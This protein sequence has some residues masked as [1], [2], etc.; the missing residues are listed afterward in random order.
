MRGGKY[1]AAVILKIEPVKRLQ[2]TLRPPSDKSLTH[3]AYMLGAI[4]AGESMVREPLLGEDCEATLRCLR[5]MGLCAEPDGTGVRLMPAD[6]WSQPHDV[7][8]CGNSGTT[9]RLMSGLVASRPLD[10]TMVGDASLSRRPMKRIAEPLRL[11][12]AT[13][14]GDTPPLRIKGGNLQSITYESPVA[15]AQIKSA[16]LLAGLR[17]QGRTAVIEPSLSRDHTERMLSALGVPVTLS[18]LGHSV[19]ALDGPAQPVGFEF[20]VPGDVSSGAFFMV[21]AAVIDSSVLDVLELG[22]NPSRTGVLDV[23]TMAGVE[24]HILREWQELGEPVADIAIQS[25]RGLRPFTIE[26]AMVPRLIDEIPV[27]AV[28]ATQCEGTTV[29]RDARELRVKESDRIE[30]VANG[31]RAMGAKVETFDDGLAVT[32][33]TPLRSA[34]ID[35]QLDHRIAMAFAVAGLI[36]DGGVEIA[37]AEAIGTSFPGFESELRRLTSV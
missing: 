25:A 9:M 22:V 16:V 27:L 28:L 18:D 36:S 10:V 4:A 3:R 23:L 21:A 20:L 34:T 37:G 26:G 14:E 19:S 12:G 6:Q 15:S 31:L 7:I 32:G 35:C 11:M 1:T 29:I 8:D 2:G 24:L 30:L 5:Q 33:S 13:V 17:A